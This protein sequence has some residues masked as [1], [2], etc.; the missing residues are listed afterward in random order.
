MIKF[1]KILNEKIQ[2]PKLMALMRDA[3][4]KGAK[5]DIDQDVLELWGL[6][7]VDEN[8]ALWQS[9]VAKTF[10]M[11]LEDNFKEDFINLYHDKKY[12]MLFNT[13]KHE[14]KREN[15]TS[16][17][18][19]RGMTV[20][21]GSQYWNML[22]DT[23]LDGTLNLKAAH[24]KITSW[25]ENEEV[26]FAF[27]H[28]RN[29]YIRGQSPINAQYR[30]G[31]AIGIICQANISYKDVMFY[32]D[33]FEGDMDMMQMLTPIAQEE[34]EVVV[35][36]PKAIKSKI[37]KA[38]VFMEDDGWDELYDTNDSLHD[39]WYN[40]LNDNLKDKENVGND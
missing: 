19:Y 21:K 34:N 36:T 30:E 15:G 27:A 35:Y 23:Y 20:P 22:H 10:N 13:I 38:F 33:V 6:N 5:K 1:N 16:V 2:R 12:E 8:D 11:F 7:D 4:K 25:S 3:I 24:Q 26:A 40:I 17:I 9:K 14:F 31:T 28:G 32:H 39:Q 29:E 37:I 18:L